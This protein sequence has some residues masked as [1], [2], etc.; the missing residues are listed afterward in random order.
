MFLKT[1]R[2]QLVE[3]LIVFFKHVYTFPTL[4]DIIFIQY[5]SLYIY[6]MYVYVYIYI[7]KFLTQAPK[8]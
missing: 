1:Q 2:N 5:Y 8:S 6:V 3:S 7:H 4:D